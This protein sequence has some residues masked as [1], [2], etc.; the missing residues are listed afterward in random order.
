MPAKPPHAPH[1]VGA[2]VGEAELGHE[3]LHRVHAALQREGEHAAVA[4]HLT[5]G[6]VV[7][8]VRLEARVVHLL[9]LV[10]LATVASLTGVVCVAKP[11]FV[12]GGGAASLDPFWVAMAIGG[13]FFSAAA[14]VVVRKLSKGGE[15]PLVIVFYFPLVTV[16]AAVPTMLPDF[17]WP[18]GTEWLLLLGIG[19]ATQIGQVSLT[20]GLAVLPAATGTAFS[21]LQVIFAAAWGVLFFGERPDTLAIA[22]GLLVIGSALWLARAERD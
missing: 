7:A 20:R 2:A 13:A 11:A 1:E 6:D 3:R 17:I 8:A 16:P 5:L 22:G 19:I 21:Y 14:Y 18:E 10:A 4:E 12:F 9:D 15:D